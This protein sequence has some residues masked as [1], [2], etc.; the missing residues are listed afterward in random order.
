MIDRWAEETSQ[1][2]GSKSRGRGVRGLRRPPWEHPCVSFPV[3]FMS[4]V[5]RSTRRNAHCP[6]W[7]QAPAPT[8]HS[9]AALPRQLSSFKVNSRGMRRG[10]TVLET[11]G[12][13]PIRLV[14]KIPRACGAR[15]RQFFG[16]N[17]A[18]FDE[19]TFCYNESF[20]CST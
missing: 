13:W 9:G 12:R 7:E 20:Y 6:A 3:S 5:L 17:Q 2:A 1:P 11:A 19:Q 15:M 16:I 4:A 14:E 18:N 10:R 8:T